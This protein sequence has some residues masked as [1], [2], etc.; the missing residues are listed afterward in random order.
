MLPP[1]F[2]NA[3]KITPLAQPMVGTGQLPLLLSINYQGVLPLLK[4]NESKFSLVPYKFAFRHNLA[5]AFQPYCA[6]W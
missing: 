3:R 1:L 6:T 2:V 5:A 4:P